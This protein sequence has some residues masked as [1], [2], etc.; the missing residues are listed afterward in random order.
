MQLQPGTTSQH[1]QGCVY[2]PPTATATGWLGEE[3]NVRERT[4]EDVK[5]YTTTTDGWVL[6]GLHSSP[7]HLSIN[8]CQAGSQV[9]CQHAKVVLWRTKDKSTSVKDK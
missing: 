6:G 8:P 9:D 4:R 3:W 2:A 7:N 1:P 5:G